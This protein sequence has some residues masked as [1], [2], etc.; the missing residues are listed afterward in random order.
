MRA[1]FE[2]MLEGPFMAIVWLLTPAIVVIGSV[3]AG[4]VFHVISELLDRRLK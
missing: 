1:M 4:L 3:G 2:G